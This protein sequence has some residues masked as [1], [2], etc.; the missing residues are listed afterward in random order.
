MIY[1]DYE[2]QEIKTVKKS[3][4]GHHKVLIPSFTLR[5]RI[6]LENLACGNK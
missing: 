1:G 2:K 3:A 4:S 5:N 6:L